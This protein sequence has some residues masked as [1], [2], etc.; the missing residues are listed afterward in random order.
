MKPELH[1][2]LQ[3]YPIVLS[4]SLLLYYYVIQIQTTCCLVLFVGEQVAAGDE[5]VKELLET[6]NGGSRVGEL[7]LNDS[8]WTSSSLQNCCP[9][10]H[11]AE[12]DCF[13][14]PF[15]LRSRHPPAALLTRATVFL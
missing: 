3:G 9:A 12:L 1:F 4:S 5:S 10:N 14:T 11:H 6:K 15:Y 7:T 13:L 2:F 8:S